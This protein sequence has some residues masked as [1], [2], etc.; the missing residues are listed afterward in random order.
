MPSRSPVLDLVDDDLSWIGESID[1]EVPE[2][3]LAAITSI[4]RV[5]TVAGEVQ[6]QSIH[7]ND[8]VRAYLREIG[9]IPLLTS[10]QEVEYAIAIE[11][12]ERAAKEV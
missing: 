7:I 4:A 5:S 9:Q 11:R 10:A 12:A 6:E 1:D 8:N 2:E 3:P